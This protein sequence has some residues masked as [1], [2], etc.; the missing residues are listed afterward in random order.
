VSELSL[1]FGDGRSVVLLSLAKV[2]RHIV[3]SLMLC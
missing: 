3:R 1:G 2:A